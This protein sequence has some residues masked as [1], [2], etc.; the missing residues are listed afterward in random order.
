MKRLITKRGE[1]TY[2]C[3]LEGELA[4]RMRGDLSSRGYKMKDG[5]P[6]AL[7]GASKDSISLTMFKSGKLLI[8]GKGAKDFIE[9]YLEP[10]I[11]RSV[12]LG[13]EEMQI[14]L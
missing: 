13:Y 3:L 12:T 4:A 1:H 5:I 6:H 8:Q 2:I 11:L 9:F 10:Y 7:F 14:K